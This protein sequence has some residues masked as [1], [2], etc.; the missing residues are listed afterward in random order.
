MKKLLSID[1]GGI[2]G[3]FAASFL[4]EVETKC[5]CRIC[6]YFDLIA[7]TSTGGIIAAALACGIPARDILNLYLKNGEKIFKKKRSIPLTNSKYDSEVLKEALT[8]VFEDKKIRDCQTRLLIPAFNLESR[9]VRVFKTPHSSDLYFDKDLLLLDCILATTAAPTYFSPH[10]MESGTFIDGGIGANNPSLIAVIEGLTRCGWDRSEIH[11]LSVG[12]VEDPG[13]TSGNE[14]MGLTD[15]L[16]IQQCY[17]MA[18]TQYADNICRLLLPKENYIRINQ[19]A[20]P[21]QVT[22]DTVNDE[23]IHLL[24]GW[25]I[26]QAQEHIHGVKDVFFADTK[27]EVKFYN[28]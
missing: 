24:K 14:K 12:C 17:M 25:G 23:T 13:A 21:K 10:V 5:N 2:K 3:V 16:K 7:G 28:L 18:E 1:G 26:H 4:A 22:L 15:A 20:L 8:D 11:V 6:D 19:L 27:G 9:S